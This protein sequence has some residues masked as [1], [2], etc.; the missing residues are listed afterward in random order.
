MF[1]LVCPHVNR[2][3]VQNNAHFRYLMPIFLAAMS[4]PQSHKGARSLP[5]LHMPAYALH[6]K[7]MSYLTVLHVWELT[8]MFVMFNC[9]PVLY[10]VLNQTKTTQLFLWMPS[11][12]DE[13]GGVFMTCQGAQEE[14]L[15]GLRT[16]PVS[17]ATGALGTPTISGFSAKSEIDR[18]ESWWLQISIDSIC[19]CDFLKSRGT[20]S[21]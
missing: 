4:T 21:S 6:L 13:F 14:R 2:S 9:W 7:Q 17:W 1:L 5:F 10:N 20:F 16:V 8:S 19:S 12:S 11:I 3:L 18:I 15:A